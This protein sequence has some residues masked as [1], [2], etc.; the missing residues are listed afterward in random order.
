MSGK[1]QH[2]FPVD[3]FLIEGRL[4]GDGKSSGQLFFGDRDRLDCFGDGVG[5][6]SIKLVPDGFSFGG[7]FFRKGMK[8]VIVDHLF[9][10]ARDIPCDEVQ[11][12]RKKI[13]NPE[14]KSRKQ[15]KEKHASGLGL[16][17]LPLRQDQVQN[18]GKAGK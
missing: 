3:D 15:P 6:V 7:C 8:Q 4:V 18:K 1:K 13:Q 11:H 12:I 5:E 9:A 2:T 17:K 14:G 16:G 10:V